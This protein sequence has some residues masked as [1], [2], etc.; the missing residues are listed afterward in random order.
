MAFLRTP[1]VLCHPLRTREINGLQRCEQ[2]LSQILGAGDG[3]GEGAIKAQWHSAG[4]HLGTHLGMLL[5]AQGMSGGPGAIPAQRRLLLLTAHSSQ[6]TKGVRSMV[7]YQ[8]VILSKHK[9]VKEEAAKFRNSASFLG[10]LL[11]GVRGSKPPWD[12][13]PA[14][15][16]QEGRD[17]STRWTTASF[18][19]S[20]HRVLLPPSPQAPRGAKPGWEC[21]RRRQNPPPPSH[22]PGLPLHSNYRGLRGFH[23][24]SS[25]AC[26]F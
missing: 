8:L 25:E 19:A 6:L 2:H 21:S 4:T 7:P 26:V 18:Q 11:S 13:S 12:W 10:K 9:A 23:T 17:S 24:Q 3:R 1:P 16:H 22:P 14:A 20:Q 15:A 5:P